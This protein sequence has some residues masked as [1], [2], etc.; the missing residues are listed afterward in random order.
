MD[1]RQEFNATYEGGILRPDAP[2]DLPEHARVRVVVENPDI[3]DAQPSIAEVA[4]QIRASGAFR[5]DGRPF[6]RAD[7][8]DRD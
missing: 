8:Y 6:N 2:L 3:K 1:D 4:R 7:L 5:S